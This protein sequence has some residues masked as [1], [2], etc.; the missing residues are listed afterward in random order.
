[1]PYTRI[2]RLTTGSVASGSFK[3]DSFTAD[4]DYTLKK[5]IVTP[6]GNSILTNV[7]LYADM[8]GT[9]IFRPDIPADLLDPLNPNN[10]EINI[11]FKKGS[12]LG[13][14]LTNSSG[15]TETYDISLILETA[16]WPPA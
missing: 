15:G 10:P 13:Y 4:A 12:K 2:H 16:A 5:I 9:P 3:E 7:Q 14:K 8:D 1:M 11:P 6:R